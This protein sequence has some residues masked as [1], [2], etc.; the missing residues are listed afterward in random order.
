MIK[1]MT[2]IHT[3]NVLSRVHAYLVDSGEE[4]IPSLLYGLASS[5]RFR[6]CPAMQPST[7]ESSK[8]RGVI[9]RLWR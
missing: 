1:A 9:A 8:L 3:I 2:L 4:V 5:Y 7:V 6:P